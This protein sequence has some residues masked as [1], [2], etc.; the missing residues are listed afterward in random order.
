FSYEHLLRYHLA[1]MVVL[2]EQGIL[3]RDRARKIAKVLFELRDLGWNGLPIDPALENIQPNLER[4]VI[5]RLGADVG[6]DLSIGRARHDFVYASEYLALREE[7]LDV[8]SSVIGLDNAL[9]DV[10]QR[11]LDTLA[12]YYT[13]HMRA[14]PI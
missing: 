14:E 6:G 2:S 9:R 7:T 13:S 10:S 1:S 12:P 8:M 4:A 5:E 3:A 11:T